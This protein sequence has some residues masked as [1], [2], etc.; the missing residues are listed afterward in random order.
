MLRTILQFFALGGLL[1]ACQFAV[2]RYFEPATIPLTVEV[3][4]DAGKG[5][6]E[7]AIKH[8]ILIDQ[9]VRLGWH[10]TDPIV[11]RHMLRNMKFVDSGDNAQ[12]TDLELIEEAVKIGMPESDAVVRARLI[13]R[14]ELSL[15]KVYESQEPTDQDL[16]RYLEEHKDEFMRDARYV[17]AHVFLSRNKRGISLLDEANALKAE[18][19]SQPDLSPADA[20]RMG[21]PLLRARAPESRTAKSAADAYGQPFADAITVA[22][23]GRWVGPI[24]S[25]F[26]A[27][28]IR[29]IERIE[30][31]V[32]PIE[33]VENQ[34]R[35]RL[36]RELRDT[37]SKDRY[38]KL[39]EHYEITVVETK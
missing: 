34:V 17:Y 11:R 16:S 19:A 29:L 3:P 38:A 21:D 26:G 6:I 36:L 35:G 23:V 2:A 13:Q 12:M 24:E 14:A 10:E 4:V 32:A 7:Q 37:N 9:A 39:R 1:F 8:E 15:E 31:S 25:V 5:H 27:H 30:A 22:Q 18:L 28:L 33:D 20:S